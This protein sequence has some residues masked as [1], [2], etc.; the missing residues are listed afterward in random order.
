MDIVLIWH[1]NHE[2]VGINVNK[3]CIEYEVVS[4]LISVIHS[5]ADLVVTEK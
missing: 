2:W 5:T 3:D 1:S 4:S